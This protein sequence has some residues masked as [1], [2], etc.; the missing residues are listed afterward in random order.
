MHTILVSMSLMILQPSGH[1]W[2][3]VSSLTSLYHLHQLKKKYKVSFQVL[4]ITERL[5][6]LLSLTY[7]SMVRIH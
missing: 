6:D 1:K 5:T 7:L 4:F 3:L 2:L